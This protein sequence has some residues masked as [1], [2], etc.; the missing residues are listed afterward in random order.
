M[1]DL[2]IRNGTV[3]TP[4]GVLSIDIAIEE[5][6]IVALGQQS[7]LGESREVIDAVGCIVVPGGI[8]PH[9]HCNLHV[10]DP[11]G[12]ASSVSEGAEHVSRAALHGGTTTLIDFVWVE[13]RETLR[14]AIDNKLDEW[15][16]HCHS[17]FTF[18]VV[19]RGEVDERIL[20]ELPSVIDGGFSSFKMFTT[21]VYPQSKTPIGGVPLKI[22]FGSMAEVLG[23]LREYGGLGV[24]HAEDDDL[25]QHSYRVHERKGRT[26]FK[27]MPEVHSAMSEDLAF[28]RVI[29]LAGHRGSA[30]L[31]FMH[32]SAE[33]GVRAIGNARESGRPIF[34]ETLHQYALR[35]QDNY[36]EPDGMKYHTYPSLKSKGDA[37][38]LWDGVRVGNISTFATDE[39]CTPYDIKT[40]GDRID[41][42]V[43]GNTGAE[44][45]MIIVYSE[46]MRRGLG[47]RKFV[48]V[49]SENS[50]KLFGLYPQKGAIAIG[51]DADLVVIDPN[52]HRTI[53]AADL[54]ESD[55]TPWEGWEVTG[56]PTVTVFQGRVVARNG[57][58]Y[59][60]PSNGNLIKRSLGADIEKG[61]DFL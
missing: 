35:T 32:V 40:A 52:Q 51:S 37:E 57:E 46:C 60:A 59:G 6:K 14:Q 2:I 20:G 16:G 28:R 23:I 11:R 56:W 50:A 44:P 58:F 53:T 21:N 27:Y 45:R 12:G 7:T 17:D 33:T 39:Q 25:V 26:H 43:G 47:L 5:G 22:D 38:S 13:P 42:V 10:D 55:Y 41:N 8:D 31:Y 18:H 48:Q 49:T 29:G 24:I 15:S 36:E 9:V 34:G 54:H 61:P 4:G 3:V 19:L 30:P 1:F